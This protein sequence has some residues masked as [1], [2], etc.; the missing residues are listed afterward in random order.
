MV[1]LTDATGNVLSNFVILDR[2]YTGH[3]HLLGV[4]L[5]HMNGRLY[6]PKLH[7]FLMPDNYVQDP[8][9]T[10]NFNRYGYVL[11]N[12]LKYTDPSGEFF[13]AILGAIAYGALI[14]AA[15]A[16]AVYT[17]SSL[18]TGNWSWSGLG[19]SILYGAIGG[20]ISGGLSIAASLSGNVA[21]S[22][23]L[24]SATGNFLSEL[25]SQVGAGAA[26]GDP[27]TFGTFAGSLA[28]GLTG[29][30][31]GDW[32]GVKGGW[33]KN[34]LGEL[35]FNSIKGAA[36]GAVSGGVGAAIDG[37]AI[38]RGIGNGI[39]NGAIGGFSQSALMI[40]MFGATYKPNGEQL[41]FANQMATA[42]GLSTDDIAWRKGGFYQ[43]LQPSLAKMFTPKSLREGYSTS[44]FAREV[45]WGRNVA[46][47][48]NTS[49]ATF[50]H[51]FGHVIQVNQQGWAAFQA[52]GIYEQLFLG[53][54]GYYNYKTNEYQAESFLQRLGGCTYGCGRI[55]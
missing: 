41:E 48:G 15:T 13:F 26:M 3:E 53:L 50:G 6:D 11:N 28:G 31:F 14:G 19:T 12:P 35:G 25:A 17:V 5:V 1:K 51:E 33:F 2:G 24:N 27:I 22:S 18:I 40:S 37:K 54:G 36:R 9:N 32:N 21:V 43:A 29:S 10:Q 20:G 45:T 34:A 4:G 23:F 44:D 46:V 39:R 42:F 16:A 52:R 30:R 8:Y 55:H 7:R 47:F 49:S 38:D